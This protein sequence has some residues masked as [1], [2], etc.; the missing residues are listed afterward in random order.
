MKGS[1]VDYLM[2][3]NISCQRLDYKYHILLDLLEE[4]CSIQLKCWR[5]IVVLHVCYIKCNSLSIY[6][7]LIDFVASL[8]FNRTD[9][10]FL[11]SVHCASFNASSRQYACGFADSSLHVWSTLPGASRL[12]TGERQ[13]RSTADHSLLLGHHGPVYGTCFSSNGEF[14]LS[15]SEDCTV[16]LW[17][18]ERKTSVV[19]Y[20]GHA[21][22]VW[23]VAFRSECVCVFVC[24][25]APSL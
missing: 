16:R 2:L 1:P 4:N 6:K 20:R 17:N 8:Q 10:D 14:L 25:A 19:S 18:V 21:Y 24:G 7:K 22:P 3:I 11:F 23:D 13:R 12:T 5:C 9:V 15:T